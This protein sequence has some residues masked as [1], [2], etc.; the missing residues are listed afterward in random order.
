VN[1]ITD[2]GWHYGTVHV[3]SP[4]PASATAIQRRRRPTVRRVLAVGAAF[5]VASAS[6]TACSTEPPRPDQ[7]LET[8]VQ[9]LDALDGTPVAGGT[10][11]FADQSEAIS[12]EILRQCGTDRD[13]HPP[14]DCGARTLEAL[15]DAPTV[16]EVRSRMLQLIDGEDADSDTAPDDDGERDRA[17]LLT[18]LHAALATVDDGTDGTDG[19]AIDQ[20][21]IDA[22][23]DGGS[24]ISEDTASALAPATELV[25]QAVYLSGVVLPVAGTNRDTVTTVST[26]MRTIRDTVTPASGVAAE[27]GYSTPD[28]FTTPTDASSA[29]SVLLDAVHA[30]TVS[31]RD[32]V[33]EVSD[34]DR[35]LTAMLCAVSARSE[36]ALEDALGEDPLAVSVR[37][38]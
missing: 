28:D 8:L 19:T 32:A 12:G 4:T 33:D 24:D 20:D 29:A 31:L 23:F 38:E 27:A 34:D 2:R 3:S 22:G 17:V 30:V 6:V 35:A 15:A 5:T 36:A 16:E 10:A 11:I 26:R 37:G 9:Q 25:N 14:E 21:M 7:N 18:G 1:P 13:G